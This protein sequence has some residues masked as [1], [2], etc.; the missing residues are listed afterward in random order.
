MLTCFHNL[1]LWDLICNLSYSLEKLWLICTLEIP[2]LVSI[3]ECYEVGDRCD[4][5]GPSTVWCLL[6]I[7]RCKNKV[8]IFI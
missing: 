8:L 2:I 1:T 5:E 3:E 6:C 7:Y 4:I